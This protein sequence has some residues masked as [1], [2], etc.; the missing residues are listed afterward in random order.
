MSWVKEMRKGLD[1]MW[2]GLVKDKLRQEGTLTEL[3]PKWYSVFIWIIIFLLV[4]VSP[5]RGQ[6]LPEIVPYRLVP[7]QDYGYGCWLEIEIIEPVK[8]KYTYQIQRE[9]VMEILM[10]RA[11]FEEI[12]PMERSQIFSIDNKTYYLVRLPYNFESSSWLDRDTKYGKE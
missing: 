3:A 9:E 12:N 11:A 1:R 7:S 4:C 6:Q 10:E 2:D 8:T 5:L